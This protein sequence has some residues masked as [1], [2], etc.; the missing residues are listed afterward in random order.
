MKR[1]I[2]KKIKSSK[3]KIAMCLMMAGLSAFSVGFTGQS[4][5]VQPVKV[6]AIEDKINVEIPTAENNYINQTAEFV[7]VTAR[8]AVVEPPKD[9]AIEPIGTMEN[10]TYLTDEN[11]IEAETVDYNYSEEMNY[12]AVM[13]MEA[14]A[15]LP[16]DGD[17]A[18]ITALGIPATY[19]VVAV[20]PSV[21]PLGSR[22]YIP[23][24]GMAIAADTGGAIVGY[25]IDLCMES[26]SEA[27]NFGRRVVTVYVL[28]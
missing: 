13:A 28:D 7:N 12:R 23:G 6:A 18:C 27:M 4:E 11:N 16:T 5:V 17:G 14:T 8:E 15:Y 22:V 21:I 2:W 19:G 3:N 26:Y 25:C 20:D 1:S 9:A 10:V 24:Y